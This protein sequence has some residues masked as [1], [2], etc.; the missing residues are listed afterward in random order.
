MSVAAGE[1]QRGV[2]DPGLWGK[3][4]TFFESVFFSSVHKSLSRFSS[5]EMST[6]MTGGLHT[7][8]KPCVPGS[9]NWVFS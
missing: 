9:V 1:V 5:T 7:H 4:N 2:H 3:E 8:S 6:P